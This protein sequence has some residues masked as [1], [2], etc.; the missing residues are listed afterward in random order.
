MA[1]R[2]PCPPQCTNVIGGGEN[3]TDNQIRRTSKGKDVGRL[4]ELQG[5][6]ASGSCDHRA[7]AGTEVRSL[8]AGPELSAIGGITS[9]GALQHSGAVA[10][11]VSVLKAWRTL[12][13][14][15]QW[16]T[17]IAC[18]RPPGSSDAVATA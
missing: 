6:L 1:R 11:P 16:P 12:C 8:S 9:A 14:G 13:L 18:P 5:I 17:A 4:N 2:R 3:W 10:A 15:Q 7:R